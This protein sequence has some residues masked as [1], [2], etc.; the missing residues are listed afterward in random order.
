MVRRCS[1]PVVLLIILLFAGCAGPAATTSQTDR[2]LITR[3]QITEHHFN[4]ALQAV[5]TLRSNWL[6]PRVPAGQQGGGEV[7]VYIDNQPAGG[8]D[9]LRSVRASDIDFIRYYDALEATARWGR[10]HGEGVIYVITRFD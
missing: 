4:T 2:S 9:V 8:V 5:Q 1:F 7:R 10:D 3:E 6:R